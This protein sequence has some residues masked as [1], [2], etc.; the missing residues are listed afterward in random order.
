MRKKY[1][2]ERI[3]R[4]LDIVMI[5]ASYVVI[6]IV[7]CVVLQDIFYSPLMLFFACSIITSVFVLS[8]YALVFRSLSSLILKITGSSPRDY[9]RIFSKSINMVS[10]V[11]DREK[12]RKDFFGTINEFVSLDS[13]SLYVFNKDNFRQTISKGVVDSGKKH[14][15]HD[16]LIVRWM[17]YYRK[18]IRKD[19]MFVGF[20]NHLLT[21]EEIRQSNELKSMLDEVSCELCVPVFKGEKLIAVLMVGKPIKF[22]RFDND[23]I[24][25][26][27][28]VTRQ[29]V[30]CLE[31]NVL[32][33]EVENRSKEIVLIQRAGRIINSN[34]DLKLKLNLLTRLVVEVSGLSRGLL[35]I[36]DGAEQ[37]LKVSSVYGLSKDWEN[38]EIDV[39]YQILVDFFKNRKIAFLNKRY[40]R[41]MQNNAFVDLDFND[42]V[43]VPLRHGNKVFGVIF[44]DKFPVKMNLND[45]DE[46]LLTLFSQQVITAIDKAVL[47]EEKNEHL[48]KLYKLNEEVYGIKLYTENILQN[49]NHA[50]IAVNN[51]SIVTV[52]NNVAQQYFGLEHSE[53][54]GRGIDT[55]KVTNSELTRIID[56]EN[57]DPHPFEGIVSVDG[58][59]STVKGHSISLS[60]NNKTFGKMVVFTDITKIKDLEKQLFFSDRLNS[61]GTMT[62]SIMHEIKN[63][64]SS[65]KILSNLMMSKHRE[66]DF[67]DKYGRIVVDEVDRL[68]DIVNNY[69]GFSK[70]RSEDD[71]DISFLEMISKVIKLMSVKFKKKN[72]NII[73]DVDDELR[74]SADEQALHQIFINMLI[75]AE[76]A[77]PD[78]QDNKN[79]NISAKKIDGSVTINIKDN[80]VGMANDVKE[81][82]FKP[83][84]TTKENGTGLG[85]SITQ[86]ILATCN[87]ELMVESKEGEGTSFIVKLPMKV[88]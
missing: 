37:K 55:L 49:L 71:K 78:E 24:E 29:Y 26:L 39:E 66:P 70:K 68:D 56:F 44:V 77:F 22:K 80:G 12:V 61:L 38:V 4:L 34:S 21:R 19:E 8:L 62:A 74:V 13:V 3:S 18:P 87:G 63:P 30:L 25:L 81:N 48:S 40:K 42:C 14:L 27:A 6:Q 43:M 35:L 60:E 85:L 2:K 54:L 59:K 86:Q 17:N 73:L 51:D 11:D 82:I 75:N 72:I 57:S 31:Q 53:I 52:F 45:H 15:G 69:L 9:K 76:Q 84:Y 7:L 20:D 65:L 47:I 41:F 23:D 10:D 36:F 83:F 88:L 33:E 1:L 58:I 28:N 50:V 16:D 46:R 67:W 32:S 79:V 64:I 5:L